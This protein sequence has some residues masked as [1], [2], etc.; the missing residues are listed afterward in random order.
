MKLTMRQRQSLSYVIRKRYQKSNKKDKTSILNEFVSNTGYNRSYA[1]RM[2]GSLKR[3]GRKKDYG[4]R[5]RIYDAQVFYPLRKIWIASDGIC[6]QRLQP[7]LPELLRVLKKNKEIKVSKVV[8]KKLLSMGSATIDRILKP[9]KRSYQLKG[10][11]TTKPG[12]L[13]K[14]SIPIRTFEQWDEKKPGFFE[15][16]LVAFCGESVKGEYVNG[17]NMTDVF[18]GWVL[19]EAVMGKAQSRVNPAI[20]NARKRLVYP[21]LGLDSDNGS[22]FINGILK[23]YCEEN[24]ITFTR[25]RPYHKNDNCFVEQK[26]YTVL[27]RFLGYARYDTQEQLEIIKEIL[28]L[29]EPYVN[30]FQPSMKLTKKERIGAKTKKKHDLAKTPYQRLMETEIINDQQKQILTAY[31]ETLNPMEIKRKINKLTEKLNK[32]LRYKIHDLTN[33]DSVT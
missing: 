27:R 7:F 3:K 10:R 14:H 21:M 22:E 20:D 29:V 15:T 32:T 4:P 26:N 9:T 23:R 28:K 18:I 11:S 33:L 12:T 16:D 31:Y 8:E 30:F 24:K 19:L 2:L 5:E 6:G 13:L 25:I 17:L 1:R